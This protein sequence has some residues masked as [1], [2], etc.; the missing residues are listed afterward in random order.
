MFEFGFDDLKDVL[1][2]SENA[3]ALPSLQH[4]EVG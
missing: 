1:K 4:I 2:G 3:P